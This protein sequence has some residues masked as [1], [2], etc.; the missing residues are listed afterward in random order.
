MRA[1]LALRKGMAPAWDSQGAE[2]RGSPAN[3]HNKGHMC[4]A[5]LAC[6]ACR[7]DNK[8]VLGHKK[9]GRSALFFFLCQLTSTAGLAYVLLLER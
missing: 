6:A 5:P 8:L 3:Q 9:G 2:P 7:C 1:I 4:L